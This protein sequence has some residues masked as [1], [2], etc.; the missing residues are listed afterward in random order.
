MHK[1]ILTVAIGKKYVDQAR[2]LSYSCM[3]NSAHTLRAVITD[4]PESLSRFYDIIIPYNKNDD[5]FSLKTRLYELTP[6][7]QTLFLDAD[8]LIFHPIEYFWSFLDDQ[9]Y[10]YEG[11]KITSGE[12]Y[13]DIGKTCKLI[14]TEWIP[15][16]NSGMILF[17]KCDKT[18]EFFKTAY[19]YFANHKSEGISIPFF[20][21][22][23][24]PDEPMLAMA[25]AKHN[26]EPINDYG[27]F[28]HTLIKAKKIHLNIIKKVAN[29]YKDEKTMYPLVVHFC[30]R[31][32]NL[33]YL[34]EKIRLWLHFH[35]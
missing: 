2:F 19:Y 34:R 25:L 6:F 35:I 5:P 10:V 23:N 31:R 14:G 29:F 8:S 3:L 1:G 26:M 17:S 13:F 28:S 15:L 18:K 7:D 4:S 16:F 33:Y 27:R 20:R 12:W 11:R 32:G 9:S 24:Y 30:G 21:G 22:Q